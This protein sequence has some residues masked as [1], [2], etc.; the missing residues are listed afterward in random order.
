MNVVFSVRVLITSLII[1]IGVVLPR[2]LFY[3]GLGAEPIPTMTSPWFTFLAL[4][5]ACMVVLWMFIKN[6][7]YTILFIALA[8]L[9]SFGLTHYFCDL[10]LPW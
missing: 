4:F 5:I 1:T 3:F 9:V 2:I 8:V 10:P 6:M 7:K